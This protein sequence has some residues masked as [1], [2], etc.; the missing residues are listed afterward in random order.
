[1]KKIKIT[2]FLIVNPIVIVWSTFLLVRLLNRD[3]MAAL[4][5]WVFIA[6]I[7]AGGLFLLVDRLIVGKVGLWTISIVEILTILTSIKLVDW[8]VYG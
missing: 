2:P 4:M 1:M 5:S 6:I 7:V 8:Y 3:G